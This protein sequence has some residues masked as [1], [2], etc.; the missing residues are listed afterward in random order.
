MNPEA[1]SGPNPEHEHETKPAIY[2][3]SLADYNNGRL[4]GTWIDATVGTDAIYEKIQAMLATSEEFAPKE[5]A[6]H[7]YEGFGSKRLGEYES[8]EYIAA[9]AEGIQ[10]HGE[11]FAAWV[12]Y[13]GLDMEDWQHF[14]DAYL[15]EYRDLEAYA[16]HI[17]DELG[18]R[19]QVDEL[20]RTHSGPT[21]SSTPSRSLKISASRVA[22]IQSTRGLEST[23][24]TATYK[25]FSG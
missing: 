9:L 8:I 18:W 19:E 2:V 17:V 3:A 23:S 12:D 15:G 21:S 24:S 22:S 25:P 5:F 16:D 7:D 4:H 13:S 14:E 10:R 11:A 20:F 6:I 1:N